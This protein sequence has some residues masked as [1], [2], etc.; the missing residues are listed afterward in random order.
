MNTHKSTILD[1]E[2]K[3]GIIKDGKLSFWYFFACRGQFMKAKTSMATFLNEITDD[4]TT[5]VPHDKTILVFCRLPANFN[6]LKEICN[7]A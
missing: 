2:I 5:R 6:I 7:F 3:S 4:K 1:S